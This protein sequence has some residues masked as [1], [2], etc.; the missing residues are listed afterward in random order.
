LADP[1]EGVE[2]GTGKAKIMR[3]ADGTLWINSFAHGRTVYDLRFDYRAAKA[4][5]ERAPKEHAEERFERVIL[6]GDLSENEIERL[7]ND[8][9]GIS[10]AA[11][12]ALEARVRRARQEQ[13]AARARE[14]HERR[15]AERRDPRPQIPAP[16][17]DAPFLPQMQVLNEVLAN[18]CSA[19]PPMRDA[20]GW[21]VQVRTRRI[22]SLHA[23]TTHGANHEDTNATRL[24]AP[25]QPLLYRLDEP[26]LAELIERQIEY[27]DETHRSVHLASVAGIRGT[28]SKGGVRG[29]LLCRKPQ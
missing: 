13:L 1:L 17:P 27:V 24:P 3:R 15:I 12:R 23:L 9:A 8:A 14:E 26:A 6:A 7:R 29:S 11:R 16:A 25:E 20:E 2:Y 19:E 18:S 10:G 22:L 5:I 21:V 28:Y 4:A